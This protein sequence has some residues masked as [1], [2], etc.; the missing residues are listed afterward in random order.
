MSG[1]KVFPPTPLPLNIPPLGVAVKVKGVSPE[2]A[3]ELD[4]IAI[5]EPDTKFIVNHA[6]SPGQR[7][8]GILVS[9][10]QVSWSYVCDGGN[11]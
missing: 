1:V 8:Y 5:L 7:L 11:R 6:V 4:V 3:V 10:G 2:Q 9:H